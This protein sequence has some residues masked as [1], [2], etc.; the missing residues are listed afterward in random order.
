MEYMYKIILDT[1]FLLSCLKFRI[2]FIS[3]IER[4][5]KFR[6][7]LCILSGTLKELE[8]KKFGKLALDIIKNKNM[9]V[10]NSKNSYVDEDI[11]SL[12][13]GYIIATNDR[14]L[15]K[16]LE[17]PIIRIKQKKYLMLY[18]LNFP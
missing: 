14:K 3:E 12:K 10:I 7:E 1:N 5:S 15:I 2:D 17:L 13:N 8:D 4:I 11:L 9:K 18:N 6:Y 16:N